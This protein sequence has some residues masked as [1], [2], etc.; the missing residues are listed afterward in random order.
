MQLPSLQELLEAGLHFGHQVKRWNPRMEQYIY[1]KRDNIHIIDLVKTHE[2]LQKAVAF[3]EQAAT[4]GKIVLFLGTKRQAQDIIVAEAKRCGMPYMEK[5][6]IG[7]L[8]T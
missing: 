3:L 7:G 5:R 4:E 6:W 2:Q 1:G 8:I